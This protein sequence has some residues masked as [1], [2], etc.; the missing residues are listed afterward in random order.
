MTGKTF[1]ELLL[2]AVDVDVALSKVLTGVLNWLSSKIWIFPIFF[3]LLLT[4]LISVASMLYSSGVVDL[5]LV[6]TD[7]FFSCIVGVTILGGEF[8]T[9][10][11][12]LDLKNF[13]GVG[14]SSVIVIFGIFLTVLIAS[15]SIINLG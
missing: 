13:L 12:S 7:C 10:V 4:G 11:L 1:L 6:L 5:V 14:D 2:V 9:S 8:S 15:S 3:R